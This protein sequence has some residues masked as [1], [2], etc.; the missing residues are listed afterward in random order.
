MALNPLDPAFF[1][2]L[3]AAGMAQ[4]FS[5]RP[6]QALELAKRSVALYPDWDSTYWIL[7]AAYVQL[8]RLAEA[9]AALPKYQSLAPGTT[10]SELGRRL[11]AR[12]PASLA[13]ILDGL[14]TAGLPE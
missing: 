1:L 8:D 4:L 12:D 7:I 6:A 9:R 5:G 3:L 11:P 10:V 13:I 2:Y 14:R